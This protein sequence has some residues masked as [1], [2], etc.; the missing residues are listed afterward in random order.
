MLRTLYL[1]VAGMMLALLAGCQPPAQLLVEK[2]YVQL[3]PVKDSPSVL[4]FT[5]RGGPAD[6]ALLS[7]TSP[8]ILRLEMHETVEENGMS[9]MRPIKSVPVPTRGKVEFAPGGK[10]VMVWGIDNRARKLGEA[11]FVFTFSTGEKIIAD[12]VITEIKPS[13]GAPADDK[14]R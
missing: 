14:A 8:S 3:S 2:A 4:Y 5:V 6:T 12:A 9:M 7:I 11:E 10:H 13:G 1:V